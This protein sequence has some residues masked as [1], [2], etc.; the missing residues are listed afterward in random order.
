[1]GDCAKGKH[2]VD[3]EESILKNKQIAISINSLSHASSLPPV[4]EDRFP[5]SSRSGGNA[6]FNAPGH[7]VGKGGA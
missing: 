1:M 2:S 4:Q 6:E 3:S 7:D 5:E